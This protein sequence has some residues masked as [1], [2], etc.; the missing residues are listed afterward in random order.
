[1]TGLLTGAPA[2]TG[3]PNVTGVRLAGGEELAAGLVIDAMGRRSR[4]AGG[5][6]SPPADGAGQ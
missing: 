4:L 6:R 2:A 5:H 3:I 1:V